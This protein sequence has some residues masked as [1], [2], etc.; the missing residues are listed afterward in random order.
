MSQRKS[1]PTGQFIDV[2]TAARMLDLS[3]ESVYRAVARGEIR[4][5][6]IGTALRLP[7]AQFD[8]LLAGGTSADEQ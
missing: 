2:R 4:A 8:A 7:R 3:P 5:L 1:E 6:K